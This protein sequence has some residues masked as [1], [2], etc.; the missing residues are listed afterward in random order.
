MR[1]LKTHLQSIIAAKVP[2]AFVARKSEGAE[3]TATRIPQLDALIQGLPHGALTEVHGPP[4][5][6]RTT[7][8][9]SFLAEVTRQQQVC[10]IVDAS[11]SL[12]PESLAAAGAHL[13]R[14]LWVR[15]GNADAAE[16][17]ASSCTSVAPS[18]FRQEAFHCPLVLTAG[19]HPRDEVRGLSQAISGLMKSD[20]SHSSGASRG[21]AS[22]GAFWKVA[23]HSTDGETREEQV[24]TDRQ[25]PRRGNDVMA[26][27]QVAGEKIASRI[28]TPLP[29]HALDKRQN[30]WVRLEQALKVTDLILHNGGFGA[31]VMDLGNV[32]PLNARRIPLATW[33]RFRR[34]V[35][36]TPTVFLLLSHE[37]C[38]Q[39]CA[40]LVLRCQRC[41]ERW[42][43]AAE[44]NC[45]SGITTLDGL[46]VGVEVM[47]RQ[48]LSS[49]SPRAVSLASWQTRMGWS[50][51]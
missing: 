10:A 1:R 19:R 29:R 28:Q 12:D 9:L 40:S 18:D 38:A 31:V 25:P 26:R 37:P 44:S 35:E 27:R 16:D 20:S 41:R 7:L 21:E 5:S 4:S 14:V 39:T 32:P 17:L 8:A 45:P 36:N 23:R 13:N 50:E 2:D 30:S 22:V 49:H 51:A 42:S 15:C 46:E 47:R 24:A 6:G 48:T 33:F 34:A 11:D 3:V 43:Q